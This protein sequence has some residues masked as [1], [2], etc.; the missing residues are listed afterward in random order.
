M[1]FRKLALLN[2]LRNKRIYA[3]HFLSSAFSVMIFFTYALLLF[4]PQL[5]GQ[6]DSTSAAISRLASMGM[7]LSQILIFIFSF[8]FLMY[9]VS[10]YLKTRTQEFGVLIMHGLSPKQQKSMVFTENMLIGLVSIAAG[11]AAGLVFSKLILLISADLLA[12]ES[13]LRFYLPLKA[14]FLTAG[15]YIVLFLLISRFTAGTLTKRDP[16]ALLQAEDRP[17]AEPKASKPVALLAL[18]LMLTG[19]GL[20]FY[21]ASDRDFSFIVLLLGVACTVIGSYFLFTQLSV[22]AIEKFKSKPSVFFKRTNLITLSELA[23]RVKDN[24]TMLF[25]VAIVS[26]V[27]FTGIGT[28]MALRSPGLTEMSNPYAFSYTSLPGNEQEEEQVRLIGSELEAAGFE[29]KTGS[30]SIKYTED[31]SALVRLSDY[32]GLAAALGYPEERL[33]NENEALGVATTVTQKTNIEHGRRTPPTLRIVTGEREFTLDMQKYIPHIIVPYDTGGS[34]LVVVTDEVFDRIPLQ[35]WETGEERSFVFRVADWEQTRDAA[36]R[37]QAQLP[38][39][40]EAKYRLDRPLV[41]QWLESIQR[42]GLILIFSVLVG[43]VFFTFAA[44]FLYL[45]LF[46]DLERGRRHYRMIGRVGLSRKELGGIMTRQ[47][48]FMF[49]LPILLAF[50][51]STMAFIALQMLVEF[52]VFGNAVILFA[53]FALVQ[54]LYFLIARWRYIDHILRTK[55]GA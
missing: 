24:A 4:H 30:F 3:A 16:L 46:T 21:F 51:H 50:V 43:I 39:T 25:M 20:V 18:V 55:P 53:V 23:Y 13:G 44:S 17:K 38:Y 48:A 42:N 11:I 41:L 37:I 33:A 40:D 12:I 34:P 26:A 7:T 6:L 15:V 47:L 45:R 49:F 22:W 5:Q 35:E 8:L 19:Y 2:V 36:N 52:S 27:A 28:T 9:S 31:G 14:I 54:I 1:T 10:S 32:N 29:Y